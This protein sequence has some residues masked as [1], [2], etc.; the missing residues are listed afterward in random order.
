MESEAASLRAENRR[1]REDLI[2]ARRNEMALTSTIARL[3]GD[4]QRLAVTTDVARQQ[5][6]H[7]QAMH[8]QVA[9]TANH[10]RSQALTAASQRVAARLSSMGRRLAEI[11]RNVRSGDG[12]MYY[13]H[14]G[15]EQAL[16]DLASEVQSLQ[17]TADGYI[18]PI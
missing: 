7:V 6:F 5:D 16:Y 13:A 11:A 1:L 12:T 14:R 10:F 15:A 3:Q 17:R 9:Y 4:L 18:G 2:D 8:A